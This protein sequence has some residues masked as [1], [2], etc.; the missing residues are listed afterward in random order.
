MLKASHLIYSKLNT[1]TETI[2][3]LHRRLKMQ[4]EFD[5]A[6]LG[7]ENDHTV[8]MKCI[9]YLGS[10]KKQIFVFLTFVCGLALATL[11]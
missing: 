8:L 5:R 10:F 4:L 3:N 11:L 9:D 2:T 1:K 6:Y 7:I